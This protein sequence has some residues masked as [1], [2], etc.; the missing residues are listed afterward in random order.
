MTRKATA[1]DILYI[2]KEHSVSLQR[3]IPV[4][5]VQFSLP[6][7]GKGPRVRVSVCP[8]SKSK[9]PD[10]IEFD[11]DGDIVELPLEI[12]EDYQDYE[13]YM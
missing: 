2:L 8:N 11:L 4:S 7:D 5:P 10:V 3:R 12:R 9:I 1:N 13:L 6:T